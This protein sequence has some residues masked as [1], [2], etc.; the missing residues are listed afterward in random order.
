MI[1]LILYVLQWYVWINGGIDEQIVKMERIMDKW[2]DESS[3]DNI[4]I[5][6]ILLLWYYYY[7]NDL[8]CAKVVNNKIIVCTL[9]INI[10]INV[11]ES[12]SDATWPVPAP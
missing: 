2:S 9:I 6:M 12:L 7:D 11:K 4:I 8:K 3:H 1:L 10:I 5:I